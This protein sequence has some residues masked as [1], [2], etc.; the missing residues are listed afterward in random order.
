MSVVSL[1]FS[2]H[3]HINPPQP[4]PQHISPPSD[5]PIKKALRTQISQGLTGGEIRYSKTFLLF[6]FK[7]P[8][9]KGIGSLKGFTLASPSA[10]PQLNL[11][12]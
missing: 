9:E 10:S 2:F 11:V 8:G 1:V 12:A 5:R 6:I 4:P 7:V 3:Q